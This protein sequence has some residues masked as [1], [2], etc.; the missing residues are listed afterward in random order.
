MRSAWCLSELAG[1]IALAMTDHLLYS[2]D[3]TG[4]IRHATDIHGNIINEITTVGGWTPW[5]STDGHLR[6][7]M[8]AI[9]ASNPDY[10]EPVLR[11]NEAGYGLKIF[12]QWSLIDAG[13]YRQAAIPA[14]VTRLQ[15]T[16]RGHAWYSQNDDPTE[17]LWKDHLGLWHAVAGGMRLWIGVDPTGGVSPTSLAIE[18]SMC[19]I[20]DAHDN[21]YLSVAYPGPLATVFVRADNDHPFK[22]VDAYFASVELM[23]YTEDNP[24]DPE[25]PTPSECRGAPR[26][27]Y[28]RAVNVVPAWVDPDR[29]LDIAEIV[30]ERS[31][32]TVTG[33]Y[34]DAG[35]GALDDKTA[36]LWD[37]ESR[38]HAM[39]VD[40]YAAHYPGVKVR[41]AG[42][43]FDPEP[44]P[45]EPE[46]EPEPPDPEPLPP[47]PTWKPHN[48]VPT[49]T[50]LGFHAAGD[51]GQTGDV[52][53]PLT[54]LGAQPPTAKVIVSLGAA[55]DIKL[56]DPSVITI[57]RIIDAPGY[58]NVEGFDYGG[59]AEGQAHWHMAAIMQAFGPHLE[60]Y[61]YIEV[62]NE[63]KPPMPEAHV[64]LAQ[65]FMYC[66]T[67]A[68]TWGM[69]LALFSHSVGT[70][71]PADWDAI[72]NTGIF[73]A[74]ARWGHCINLHEYNLN[75]TGGCLYRYRDLYE[76]IIL[77][78]QLD[79][80]LY[81]TE[82]N[83]DV[84]DSE[85]ADLM[86][87]D[88]RT[89]DAEVARDPYVAGVHIYSTGEVH[90]SYRPTIY[91]LWDRY[92]AYAIAVKD[93][94]N[95]T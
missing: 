21:V 6:P 10:L 82:Y 67:I 20:F 61:D 71:E 86:F 59:S 62:I 45:P 78:K 95:A 7:E 72:A 90:S 52:F 92:R 23:G 63:Q 22:H 66:M 44:P 18:W 39:Y 65:F 89:Y 29:Y 75:T 16:L 93:R 74:A 9:D 46:P 42:D 57:G 68:N 34:D 55:R 87:H 76:R 24:E 84:A 81:I 53:V 60:W 41:F 26:V 14:G 5:W 27:Q 50:K 2:E 69:K 54:P 43:I 28:V 4:E 3:F 94:K 48:Y 91:S 19:E 51:G 8:H 33:S 77:P 64:K 83:V 38:D 80:P 47:D 88:W 32:E 13:Y 17:S 11:L 40:W 58:G 36:V 85:S 35:L 37:I 31:R 12:K 56:I 79:I 49:G 73:E 15:A 25:P 70:P 1:G 30:W